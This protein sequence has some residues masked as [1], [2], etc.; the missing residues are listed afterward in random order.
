MK[1][2]STVS[3]AALA[4]GVLLLAYALLVHL[5][6]SAGRFE[7]W[8]VAVL[9]GAWLLTVVVVPWD[10]YFRARTVLADAAPTRERGLPVDERQVAYVR[11]IARGG[12]A[13]AIGLHVS[14]A[15]V[16]LALA[17]TGVSKVGYAGSVAALLL[18]GVR[19]AT[20]AYRY[21]ADRLRA[22][23]QQWRYPAQDVVEL[24]A[25]VDAAEAAVKR[26]DAEFDA[27]RPESLLSRQRDEAAQSRRAIADVAAAVE[28]ARAANEL[29]HERLAREARSAVAR[30]TADGQFLDHVREIIR[31]WKSA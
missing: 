5:G 29:D 30:I 16:L 26:F 23:H 22:I 25:R 10:V 14:T 3:T 24:R 21:L 15:A 6:V 4:F 28:A 1:F 31:F 11:R 12:L 7:D 9:A 13:L 19:P 2:T 20:A 8:V 18:T 17:V 27:G